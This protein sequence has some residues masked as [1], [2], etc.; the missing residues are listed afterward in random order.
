ME[1]FNLV[2]DAM[3]NGPMEKM[4]DWVHEDFL[5]FK[6]YGM[7]DRDEWMSEIRGMVEGDWIFQEP[8]LVVENEDVLVLNHIVMDS[9][10]NFR[11]TAVHFLKDGKTWR[12][13]TH[14]TLIKD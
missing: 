12:L 3:N 10:Q 11:V 14:R 7:Q 2:V 1:K 4:E 9:G 5:F 6:D 13:S 8:N